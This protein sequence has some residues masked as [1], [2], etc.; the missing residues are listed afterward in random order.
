MSHRHLMVAKFLDLNKLWSSKY[1]RKKIEKID[2][3]EVPLHYGTQEQNGSPYL[4]L[5][6]LQ[7]KWPSLSRKNVEIEKF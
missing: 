7:C 5:I 3:Y 2:M 1:C 4:S 6:V